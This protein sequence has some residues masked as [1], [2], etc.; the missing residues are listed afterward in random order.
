MI[1][2]ATKVDV[3]DFST[4]TH[5][6]IRR[7]H[8]AHTLILP[9]LR[10]TWGT[11][12]V[13]GQQFASPNYFECTSRETRRRRYSGRVTCNGT[14]I[15]WK[16]HTP[17]RPTTQFRAALNAATAVAMK[18]QAM[19]A[20]SHSGSAPIIKDGLKWLKGDID[21]HKPTPKIVATRIQTDGPL[22]ALSLTEVTKI[23]SFKSQ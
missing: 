20:T 6:S 7:L 12:L 22:Q 3:M 5:N 13:R 17:D 1:F 8:T 18:F 10:K 11:Q 19:A 9:P 15:E 2:F 4:S 14:L 16:A 21:K 23:Y